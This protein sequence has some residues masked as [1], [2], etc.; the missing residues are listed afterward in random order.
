MLIFMD[1]ELPSS[2]FRCW[3]ASEYQARFVCNRYRTLEEHSIVAQRLYWMYYIQHFESHMPVLWPILRQP[4]SF[5]SLSDRWRPRLLS[6]PFPPI[7]HWLRNQIVEFLEDSWRS[8]SSKS[9]IIG[10][11]TVIS[12]HLVDSLVKNIELIY[13]SCT[14]FSFQTCIGGR[15]PKLAARGL[16]ASRPG[17]QPDQ[18]GFYCKY[19]GCLSCLWCSSWQI[20]SCF[21][22]QACKCHSGHSRAPQDSLDRHTLDSC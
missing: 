6:R 11:F 12:C 5:E 10:W 15:S 3:A 20:G 13:S 8:L 18:I 17:S 4:I 19:L 7:W 21:H 14:G 2:A 22:H 1:Y 16:P 9:W